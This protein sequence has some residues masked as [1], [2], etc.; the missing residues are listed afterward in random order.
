MPLEFT[1]MHGLGNDYVYVDVH[2]QEVRDPGALARKVSDRHRG[3]GWVYVDRRNVEFE[4]WPD[5]FKVEITDSADTLGGNQ[6]E[7]EALPVTPFADFEDKLM[8]LDSDLRNGIDGIDVDLEIDHSVGFVFFKCVFGSRKS[9]FDSVSYD[10]HFMDPGA[11]DVFIDL[12][13]LSSVVIANP[14]RTEQVRSVH[15]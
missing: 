4:F 14:I 15:P 10:I 12:R 13:G 7:T 9:G 5:L 6:G 8:I 1:K 2:E 11:P 3:V